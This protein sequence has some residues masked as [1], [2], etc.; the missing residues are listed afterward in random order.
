MDAVGAGHT[1]V[2]H[3]LLEAQSDNEFARGLPA[4]A[5]DLQ[6]FAF[7]MASR[8]GQANVVRV[9]L[10]TEVDPASKF[11]ASFPSPTPHNPPVQSRPH[12]PEETLKP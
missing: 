9:M 3:V 12:Y 7:I 6:N 1:D 10:D 5:G 2:A 4:A 11:L 8:K